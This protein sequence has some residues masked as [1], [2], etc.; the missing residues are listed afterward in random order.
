MISRFNLTKSTFL[1]LPYC[2]KTPQGQL[3]SDS[4]HGSIDS[5][6][7]PIPSKLK[8]ELT[9]LFPT[10][11]DHRVL[12]LD[13]VNVTNEIKSPQLQI[14]LTLRCSSME[15]NR[16]Y[17][18][19]KSQNIY[20]TQPFSIPKLSEH[21]TITICDMDK[22]FVSQLIRCPAIHFNI[23]PPTISIVITSGHNDLEVSSDCEICSLTINGSTD[24]WTDSL[25]SLGTNPSHLV[26]FG[27]LNAVI[28]QHEDLIDVV[29]VVIRENNAI[30]LKH[31]IRSDERN[32]KTLE[33]EMEGCD[34]D[35]ENLNNSIIT[36]TLSSTRA[37][38]ALETFDVKPLLR[39]MVFDI[40]LDEISKVIL[41]DFTNCTNDNTWFTKRDLIEIC[42]KLLDSDAE[43]D[44]SVF[45]VRA[46]KSVSDVLVQVI[47][48][49][50]GLM[51]SPT[52]VN[53]LINLWRSGKSDNSLNSLQSRINNVLSSSGLCQ[54]ADQANS[55]A[56]LSHRLRL[57]YMGPGGV[58]SRSAELNL[59]EIQRWY[60]GKICPI[61]SPEGQGI[62]LVNE[63]AM[64]AIV[65]ESGHIASP[66]FKTYGGLISDQT[67][68]L[69]HFKLN[70]FVMSPFW[71]YNSKSTACVVRGTP[72]LCH[73]DSVNLNLVS[74]SQ[75]FSISVNLIPFLHHNDPTRA[76]MA[77][78]MYK[79]AVP[80]INPSPPLVGTGYENAAIVATQ[81]NVLATS[82]CYVISANSSTIVVY[83]TFTK[84][85]KTYNLPI[86]R[87]TNQD[88]CFRL[89][90]VVKPGQL[91]KSGDAIAECQSSSGN[92]MSLGVNL[93]VAF[94]CWGGFN[95]ED[96]V[97]LSEDVVAKGLFQS[98]HVIELS[99]EVLKTAYGNEILTNKISSIDSHHLTNLS[100]DGLISIGASV[101]D[102]DVLVGKLTPTALTHFESMGDVVK[103][104]NIES[105]KNSSIYAPSNIEDA[106]VVDVAFTDANKEHQSKTA[107]VTNYI[108]LALKLRLIKQKFHQQVQKLCVHNF[109]TDELNWSNPIGIEFW[110]TLNKLFEIYNNDVKIATSS[111]I[112][113]G[114]NEN[115]TEEEEPPS[116]SNNWDDVQ[117]DTLSIDNEDDDE[118]PSEVAS[119]FKSSKTRE[120]VV[121][122]KIKVK[123]LTCRSIQAG[124]KV[125]GRHGNKGVISRIVPREDMPYTKSGMP[126]DIILN[127]LGVPSR[128][129]I[130]Q[131]LET[132]LG[133][134]V[135]KWGDEFVQELKFHSTS[136]N[137]QR[138]RETLSSKLREV[139]PNF[140]TSDF[141]NKQVIE[142]AQQFTS[143][144]PVS[145][146]PFAKITE[147]R[148]TALRHRVRINNINSQTQLYDGL[149]GK[150]FNQKTTVG[151]IYIF[152]LNHMVEDKM[153]FRSTGP[154]SSLTQQP[155]KGKAR[156]GGQRMGEME[157]WALQGH[158]AAF[159]LKEASTLKGDD[160]AIRSEFSP[161]VVASNLK[162]N[163]TW[164]ESFLLLLSELKSLCIEV[165]FNK[166]AH[167][168]F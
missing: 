110:Q 86:V 137:L 99:T 70:R 59:R 151:K 118:S 25:L 102:G 124:D 12:E 96:S 61:E 54:F 75:L 122:F 148:W 39:P 81:H 56:E 141:N 85:Y 65:D 48:S 156:K 157:V 49:F 145:C 125:S 84:V 120:D 34:E 31:S 131:I 26:S 62:G 80:L 105:T 35:D 6:Q 63:F 11:F 76:L 163:T 79:Q 154:Y 165:V 161:S 58:T 27:N 159:F 29:Q 136:Q 119:N 32:R 21:E 115:L 40:K 146:P 82:D 112:S 111:E 57:T 16:N 142:M 101:T 130:G 17:D 104:L 91:L 30:G 123:L 134:I 15:T 129:N 5:S 51:V 93:N 87:R 53:S 60:F 164:G 155:T 147:K 132:Q 66:Y 150:P 23:L 113:L 160:V 126:V 74:G 89:R 37:Y 144:V 28:H 50:Y 139:L 52:A 68:W 109:P 1:P 8:L 153:Y 45:K 7:N 36:N 72:L 47:A 3:F 166:P 106:T 4:F 20:V 13:N 103:I 128:M 168:E 107:K 9:K 108:D 46:T 167:L 38:T 42:L 114:D 90:N 14:N 135:S 149:T 95:Y 2:I 55:L 98:L 140:D 121:L 19:I 24:E 97:I 100:D 158:G 143:G 77:A 88:T 152:K 133:L 78:N 69:N 18:F 64:G 117:S 71:M 162:L 44:E 138:S 127:P 67:V 83:D 41:N 33:I 94:M 116:E 10:M 43:F 92:E 22:V 73:R